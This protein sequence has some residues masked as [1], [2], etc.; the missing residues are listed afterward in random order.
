MAAGLLNVAV[1]HTV[2]VGLGDAGVPVAV[3]VGVALGV[4]LGVGIGVGEAPPG[5]ALKL[6]MRKR[7]LA[8]P[9]TGTYSLTT[10]K[11]VSSVGS[12]VTE[13]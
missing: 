1:P 8:P 9:V 12:T 7:Q 13:E 10:Q 11:V 6:P 3:A 4:T 2:A 5:C